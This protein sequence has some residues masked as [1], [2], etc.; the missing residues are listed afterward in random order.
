MNDVTTRDQLEPLVYLTNIVMMTDPMTFVRQ[1]W[2]GGGVLLCF[3]QSRSSMQMLLVPKALV[4]S[5]LDVD[6]DW[7]N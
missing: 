1:R 2:V 4:Y 3:F 7:D 6:V 5:K